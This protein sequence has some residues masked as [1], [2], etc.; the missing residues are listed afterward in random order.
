MTRS[1]P[2][3]HLSTKR[4]EGQSRKPQICQSDLGTW[5]DVEFSSEEAGIY[6]STNEVLFLFS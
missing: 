3:W 6:D 1:W 2:M 4:A 5:Q